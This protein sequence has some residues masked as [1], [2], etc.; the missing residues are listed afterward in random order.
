MRF[1]EFKLNPLTEA[2]LNE[3]SMSP[4]ALV[5]WAKSPAAD[6]MLMGIEFEMCVPGVDLSGE[7]VS[8]GEYDYDNYDRPVRFISD[9][10]EFFSETTRNNP[11]RL[12]TTLNNEFNEWEEKKVND[13]IDEQDDQLQELIADKIRENSDWDDIV[14]RAADE[15]GNDADEDE[16]NE[17]AQ[18]LQSED[19]ADLIKNANS[20]EYN[21]AYD[22]AIDEMRD[23]IRKN[24][25]FSEE[26]WLNYISIYS[27]SDAE[28]EWELTWPYTMA[29]EGGTMDD[30][31]DSFQS[32]LGLSKVNTSTGYHGATREDGVWSIETD[33][34]I[35]PHDH[36]DT[37]FEFISPAEPLAQALDS[38]DKIWKWATSEGCYTNS[39]TGLH[40]NISVPNFSRDKLDF[41]KLALFMGDD[42]VLEQFGR[43]GN[44][45]CRSAT[46]IIQQ[47]VT[48]ENAAAAL[49]KMRVQLS[50]AARNFIHNGA[51]DKYTSINTKQGYVEF[52]GPGG[53]Y[54]DK[55]VADLTKTALRLAMALQIACDENAH[56]EEYAKKLY[57]LLSPDD[58]T[59]NTVY[60]FA[61]YSAGKLDK[62]TLIA[63]VK[64]IQ[65]V[66]NP[67][68]LMAGELNNDGTVTIPMLDIFKPA[69]APYL[70]I[71]TNWIIMYPNGDT[72]RKLSTTP[73]YLGKVLADLFTSDEN[74]KNTAI[75]SEFKIRLLQAQGGLSPHGTLSIPFLDLRKP[76]YEPYAA[77]LGDWNILYPNGNVGHNYD[78]TPGYLAMQIAD[79]NL[80]Q[81]EMAATM[82]QS[83][84]R[85]TAR[86][87]APTHSAT[88]NTPAP[89]AEAVSGDTSDPIWRVYREGYPQNY[90]LRH[91]ATQGD[92]LRWAAARTD[93]PESNF[94][95]DPQA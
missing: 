48:S 73:A 71:N 91:S 49:E 32:A 14:A 17:R 44:T 40:M 34:S 92:A 24:S 4:A 41:I 94:R 46:T 64:Q 87:P 15:L 18:E 22:E 39:S 85:V 13:V 45:Y 62:S 84:F 16:I 95:A 19:I 28:N 47:R 88:I 86:P 8:D 65:R 26:E 56:R 82:I 11:R 69:Y 55:P 43:V 38:M 2:I 74:N 52:R 27:L 1:T 89:R 51:T 58:G 37:G 72:S 59:N 30:M 6:G 33:S 77:V 50:N 29:S 36:S 90:T 35:D 25:N 53:D 31:T 76:E 70:N 83:A 12:E 20:F 57:K 81:E 93:M 10:V 60:L 42:Y 3:V 9:I 75:K 68:K 66:R 7:T 5:S 61:K 79:S 67:N 80:S 63:K 23:T 78:V 21:T 54:L